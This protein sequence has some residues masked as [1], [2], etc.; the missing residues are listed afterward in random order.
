[1]ISNGIHCP[2]CLGR[3]QLTAWLPP[4]GYDPA[5][6]QYK[7]KNCR[8]ILYKNTGADVGVINIRQTV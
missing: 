6:R 2:K 5:I 7:C 8:V 4:R 3:A 1:M